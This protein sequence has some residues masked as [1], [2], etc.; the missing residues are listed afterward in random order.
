MLEINN[1]F[2]FLNLKIDWLQVWDMRGQSGSK[3]LIYFKD[4]FLLSIFCGLS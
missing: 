3:E 2:Y 4:S 1:S